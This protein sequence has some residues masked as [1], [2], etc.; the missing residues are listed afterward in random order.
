[1]SGQ[2]NTRSHRLIYYVR[3]PRLSLECCSS[4]NSTIVSITQPVPSSS[5][6][7]S[8]SST[9]SAF[10]QPFVEFSP[11]P[12]PAPSPAVT[13]E[14]QQD[15]SPAPATTSEEPAPTTSEAPPPPSTTTSESSTTEAAPTASASSS[16]EAAPTA[17][18]SPSSGS[19]SGTSQ[20]DI[21]K[22]LDDHNTARS[23][24]GAAALTWNDTLAVAAQQWANGC[25]F[26]HSGGTLGPYGENLAAGTGDSYGIDQAIKSWT[27]EASQFSA[28]SP[29]ASHFTQVVWK[30]S[31]QVGCAL[32]DC[33][34]IFAASFGKAH[35]YVC[36]Y[37]PQGNVIGNFASVLCPL[38]TIRMSSDLRIN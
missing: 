35:Y 18:T 38:L 34:G 19:S 36:E 33:D 27:D 4:G 13:P 28:I 37:F 30:A 31:T 7:D 10:V 12:F 11:A 22:Y 32:Q 23:Q 15:P 16:S 6:Q 8:A 2:L 26:Q 29:E 21:D 14:A 9:P 20:S 3:T 25:V 1:M 24:H 5:T 17:S